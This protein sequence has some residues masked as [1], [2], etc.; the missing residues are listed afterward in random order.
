MANLTSNTVNGYF[1]RNGTGADG[2]NGLI[3][4]NYQAPTA[5]GDF[6]TGNGHPDAQ[7]PGMPTLGTTTQNGGFNSFAEE[8]LAY[9]EFPT[10]GTYVMGVNSDDGFRVTRGWGAANNK[11]A[12]VVNGPASIAGAK[13]TAPSSLI[14]RFQTNAISGQIVQA[15]G[16]GNG[17]TTAAE[18]CAIT[19]GA[20]LN[21]KIALI[22]RGTCGFAAKVQNAVA[23]GAIAVVIVQ[24]R[25]VATPADG[26]FPIE[27]GIT[28][29]QDIPAVMIKR[30]DGDAI[31]TALSNNTAVVSVTITPMDYL[32]NPPANS[33][34][35]GQADVGRGASVGGGTLFNVTVPTA[36]VFPLRLEWFQGGGGASVEWFS[37]DSTSGGRVLLNDANSTNGPA[38]K[39]FYG[40]TVPPT[41]SLQRSGGNVIIDYTGTLQMAPAITG[42]WTDVY[43]QP[44]LTMPV[45]QAAMQFFR[46]R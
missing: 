40:I 21:G 9:V 43:G 25:P 46:A 35:L 37:V 13:A 2:S 1:V 8:I 33:P 14:S 4:F 34:V 31:V 18:A 11:G 23:A 19:N 27:L 17:S 44:P 20:L 45:S 41:V 42:P 38:L 3:K 32:V 5:T 29:I 39:A 36:G 15:L 6:S 22:Y 12:L 26:W 28:P 30:S 7:F 16:V 10:N 24:D